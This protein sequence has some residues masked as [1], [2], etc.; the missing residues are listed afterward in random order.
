MYIYFLLR[1][2]NANLELLVAV[3]VTMAGVCL[4]VKSTGGEPIY[5]MGRG[6]ILVTMNENPDMA[7]EFNA[8]SLSSPFLS[9]FELDSVHYNLKSLD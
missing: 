9:W 7:R 5:E 8:T 4:K 2:Q 1:L 3:F 6:K